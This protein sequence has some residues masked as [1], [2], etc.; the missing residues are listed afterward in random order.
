MMRHGLAATVLAATLASL[1]GGCSSPEQKSVPF[2][3]GDFE[4]FAP[5]S[6]VLEARCGTLDCHGSLARPMRIFGQ[7]GLR[8]PIDFA[9]AEAGDPIQ[10]ALADE[11]EAGADEYY[12]G[13]AQATT[14]SERLENY[15]AMC[16]LEPELTA[17]VVQG[18]ADVDTLTLFRK[19]RLLEKHKGG[20]IFNEG[21]P[22]DVCLAQWLTKSLGGGGGTGGAGG[23]ALSAFDPAPCKAELA[24][25]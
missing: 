13:G 2:V 8:R 14:P 15:K 25:E 7:S 22:G 23:V 6:T 3:C 1:W 24:K 4:S 20:R 19:M 10:K 16:G 11:V 18:S 17:R 21:Q 5:V 9:A 12:P